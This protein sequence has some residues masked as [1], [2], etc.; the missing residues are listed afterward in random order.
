LVRI[1][2]LPD[3]YISLLTISLFVAIS[4]WFN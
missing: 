2:S 3:L 1:S 4:N